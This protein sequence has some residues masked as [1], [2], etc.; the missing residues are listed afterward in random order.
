MPPASRCWSMSRPGSNAT[1]PPCSPARLLNSQPMGFYAPAQIVR[2]A[3][4][5]GVEVRAVDVNYSDWDSTLERIGRMRSPLRLGLRQIDGIRKRSGADR[6]SGAARAAIRQRPRRSRRREA[7]GA[8]LRALAEADAFGSLGPRPARGAVGGAGACQTRSPAALRRADA[9]ELREEADAAAA[10]D[11]A[12][13]ACRG[14]LPDP[15]PV[16]E[17]ASR[18]RS[19]ATLRGARASLTAAQAS[20]EPDA[21]SCGRRRGSGAPAARQ[22]Q[23]RDLHHPGGR[24]R[25]RQHRRLGRGSSSA[26][27]RM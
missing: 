18:W 6:S 26:S 19:C 10:P 27:A 1:I 11:A 7:A 21:S 15:A 5:H 25:H 2:D 16:A 14:R 20:A 12:R 4:E 3:R 22:R 24:D 13:R 8:A 9:R 23:G 17:G